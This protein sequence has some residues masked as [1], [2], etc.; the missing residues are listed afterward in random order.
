M[1]RRTTERTQACHSNGNYCDPTESCDIANHTQVVDHRLIYQTI[2]GRSPQGTHPY[3]HYADADINP[4]GVGGSNWYR[5]TGHAGDAIPTYPQR[6]VYCGTHSPGWISAAAPH[7]RPPPNYNVAGSLPNVADGI[8]DA[9]ACFGRRDYTCPDGRPPWPTYVDGLSVGGLNLDGD[10]AVKTW[11]SQTLSTNNQAE[12]DHGYG[13]SCMHSVTVSM[14]NCG[15]FMLWRLPDAPVCS[16]GYCTADAHIGRTLIVP[17]GGTIDVRGTA[18]M[19][20]VLVDGQVLIQNEATANFEKIRM[21]GTALSRLTLTKAFGSVEEANDRGATVLRSRVAASVKLIVAGAGSRVNLLDVELMGGRLHSDGMLTVV[22]SAISRGSFHLTGTATVADSTFFA[23][24]VVVTRTLREPRSTIGLHVSRSSFVAS[25]LEITAVV[26]FD[27]SC[28]LT[29][30]AIVVHDGGRLSL[31]QVEII[32]NTD[33]CFPLVGGDQG[34]GCNHG[35]YTHAAIQIQPGLFGG[36]AMLSEVVFRANGSEWSTVDMVRLQNAQVPRFSFSEAD[37]PRLATY[38]RSRSEWIPIGAEAGN[39]TVV[40]SQLVQPDGIVVPFPCEGTLGVCEA[41]YIG[42]LLVQGQSKKTLHITNAQSYAPLGYG[43]RIGY[44]A[45]WRPDKWGWSAQPRTIEIDMRGLVCDVMAGECVSKQC[46]GVECGEHGWCEPYGAI[47]HCVCEDG[48]DGHGPYWGDRCE[49]EPV[50]CCDSWLQR[51]P[52]PSCDHRGEPGI[53]FPSGY[54]PND[55]HGDGAC[56]RPE[57]FGDFNCGD[58]CR[59]CYCPNVAQLQQTSWV[60]AN[61][62]G[63][64]QLRDISGGKCCY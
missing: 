20:R 62:Q 46:L 26:V 39:L 1:W 58:D 57:Q 36:K 44:G 53:S 51:N 27:S 18:A 33:A 64:K 54:T 48:P 35:H 38:A 34:T 4:T 14:V 47:G 2:G 41:P 45:Y 25:P 12:D 56:T 32:T 9:V 59:L 50:E 24:D 31:Q 11:P 19:R 17:P 60:P 3:E 5:I 52:S 63:H 28:T 23:V 42:P 29:N 21:N 55:V 8:V 22:D 30:S 37:F 49:N 16:S 61:H 13:C 7:S 10:P 43:Q 6:M 40:R 15:G